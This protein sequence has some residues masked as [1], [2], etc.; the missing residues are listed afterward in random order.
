VVTTSEEKQKLIL[1]IAYSPFFIAENDK[2]AAHKVIS[3]EMTVTVPKN[4]NIEVETAIANFKGIGRFETLR[5]SLLTGNC[6]LADF[7]GDAG[8]KTRDGNI[9]V[10]ASKK[11][12]GKAV[13]QKGT[14]INNLPVSGKYHILA[15]SL[16]GD[17]SLLQTK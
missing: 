13:S 7:E 15:E 1:G 5:A 4:M 10:H 9:T 17:I 11:V 12:T 8:I 14:V 6:E 3:I 16:G 2:L